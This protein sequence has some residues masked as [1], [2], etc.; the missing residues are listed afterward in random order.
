[1]LHQ[2]RRLMP[3]LLSGFLAFTPVLAPQQGPAPATTVQRAKAREMLAIIRTGIRDEY[4][5]A[6]FRGRDLNAHFK[7]ADQKLEVAPTLAAA[8][9]VI[10]Q[11]M[12]DFDDAE[13]N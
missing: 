1:M 7:A 4:Y 12:V 5:D 3:S 8:Y 6:T 10:A 13:R 2:S 9:G 11:A